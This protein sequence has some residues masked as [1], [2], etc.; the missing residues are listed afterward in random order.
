MKLLSTKEAAEIAGVS[1]RT[2]RR[3]CR[4][5]RI[6]ATAY[7]SVKRPMF[8]IAPEALTAVQP[9]AEPALTPPQT[10]RGRRPR[11]SQAAS[12]LSQRRLSQY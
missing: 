9:P 6:A 10:R 12:D 11:A 4:E 3:R 5:G 2:M 7:G 1:E 8:R